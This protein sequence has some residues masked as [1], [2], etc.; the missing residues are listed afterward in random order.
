MFPARPSPA[1]SFPSSN[2]KDAPPSARVVSSALEHAGR[3]QGVFL[4]AELT[5]GL[6]ASGLQIRPKFKVLVS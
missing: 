2:R 3:T 5:A 1:W 4:V 6:G